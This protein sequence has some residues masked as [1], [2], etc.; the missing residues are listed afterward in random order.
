MNINWNDLKTVAGIA[1]VAVGAISA[2]MSIVNMISIA[3]VK[4]MV[5]D[6]DTRLRIDQYHDY[7]GPK[8]E[9]EPSDE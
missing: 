4:Q 8:V 6:T 1:G 2:G 5:L 7:A 9:D 3:R